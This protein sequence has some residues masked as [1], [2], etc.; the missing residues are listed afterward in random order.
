M[1]VQ[2]SSHVRWNLREYFSLANA[3]GSD[4]IRGEHDPCANDNP[5]RDPESGT[6]RH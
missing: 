5:Q 4:Q 3:D 6:P 2:Q 1:T